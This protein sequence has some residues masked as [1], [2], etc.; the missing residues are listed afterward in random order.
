VKHVAEPDGQETVHEPG[1]Q[2]TQY[3]KNSAA[4]QDRP[5]AIGELFPP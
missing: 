4:D 5:S 1:Q 3:S 2:E